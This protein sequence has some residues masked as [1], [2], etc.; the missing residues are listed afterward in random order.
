MKKLIA[1]L[2]LVG[3]ATVAGAQAS[4]APGLDSIGP[5]TLSKTF[6][7]LP[8]CSKA[9]GCTG[10]VMICNTTNTG[11]PDATQCIKLNASANFRTNLALEVD[12]E[13]VTSVSTSSDTYIVGTI[14]VKPSA[15]DANV[16][17]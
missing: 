17:P 4:Y 2:M 14:P 5:L 8:A 7:G 3:L 15:V 9:A 10:Y 12:Q 13:T 11:A 16:T 6:A 1:G